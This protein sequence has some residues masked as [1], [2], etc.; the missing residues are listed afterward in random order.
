MTTLSPF[1]GLQRRLAIAF[2]VG[3]TFSGIGYAV[4]DPGEVPKIQGVT[5]FPGQ[6]NGD[7]KI[8]SILWYTQDGKVRAAGAEAR[9]PG[10]TLIA[11]DEDLILAEWWKLHLR[12]GALEA[13]GLRAADLKP[14]P[15]KKTVIDIFA[16][17]LT[18]LFECTK[19]YIIET[20]PNGSSLWSSVQDR[21]DFTLSHPNGWEGL[22][23][24]KM[25]QAAVRAGLVPDTPTGH[26]RVH[27]VTEGEA[28]LLYCLD[29]GL[30]AEAIKDGSSV[31][32]VDTGG[33]TVDIS[34]YKFA[35]TRPVSVEEIAP[36]D[37]ILQGSTR[38]NMRALKFLK[39]KLANS[40]YGNDEDLLTMMENF[41]RSTKPTFK[42]PGDRSFI[43]FGSMRDKDP[44]VNIRSGQLT[45][46]GAE[47]ERFF[48]PSISS[49]A[50]AV[51]AQ[52]KAASELITLVFLVGGFAASPWLYARLR[53]ILQAEGM[54][55]SR[56]DNHTN[57]AVAE[58]A[59]SYFLSNSVAARISRLTYGAPCVRD[60]VPS[61]MEHA[62]R[63]HRTY[64]RPS[65]RVVV[66]D[67]FQ[68]ILGKGVKVKENEELRQQFNIEAMQPNALRNISSEVACYRGDRKDPK[69]MDLEP[70]SFST[71]CTIHADT[72]HVTRQKCVGTNGHYYAQT[73]EIVL[74]CGLTEMKAQISWMENGQEKRGAAKIVYDDVASSS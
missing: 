53:A 42:D 58:G 35:S 65:G 32:V 50:A 4:L 68:V 12:P 66:P 19:T 6:E 46:E 23:Q 16:D 59:V 41:E 62:M 63:S 28:S 72:S 61:D 51:C 34:T 57:K 45:L 29:S 70:E 33:G 22:Q 49:I 38:V 44:D 20:H 5:R 30:A 36:P 9:D 24:G 52:R 47:V 17:F 27:F 25:R 3:T 2:D 13:D 74:S 69:W 40:R 48:E 15:P 21:I 7:F 54:E 73:F 67:A 56:P 64:S 26:A 18:Y 1:S 60:Y 31:M 11:E 10:M 55:L 39:A 43:K 8:P 37:C 14:L 71:L